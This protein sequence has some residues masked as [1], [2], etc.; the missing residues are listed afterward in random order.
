MGTAAEMA[1]PQSLIRRLI[2]RAGRSADNPPSRLTA[3]PI[4]EVN[5]YLLPVAAQD[6][7]P[8]VM[9]PFAAWL[10]ERNPSIRDGAEFDG[11]LLVGSGDVNSGDRRRTDRADRCVWGAWRSNNARGRPVSQ[12]IIFFRSFSPNRARPCA[13]RFCVR[14]SFL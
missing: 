11:L 10:D 13:G 12:T 2:P 14:V 8:L 7:V 9:H 4:I 6:L 1:I 3:V 5:A